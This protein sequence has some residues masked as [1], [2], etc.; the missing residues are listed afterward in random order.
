MLLADH[1]AEVVRVDR[2]GAGPPPAHVAREFDVV[3]RGRRSIV[4]DLKHPA[5]VETFL[6]LVE[7]A[8]G[9]LEGFRP[10]VMERLGLGPEICLARNPRLV[11]G[12]MTGFGQEGPLSQAAG[13]DLNYL[14]LTGALHAI[15]RPGERP[16][17]PLNLVAD[18]G[19]GTM[20]L[21]FGM[22]CALLE[23]ER[24]GRGQVVD[25]AM[26]DGVA[27]LAASYYGM[28]AA[29]KWGEARGTNLLDGGCPFYETY[30]TKDGRHVAV[31]ALENK[32]FAELVGRLGL[33]DGWVARQMDRSLWPELRR[34][35]AAI[36][37]TKS[38]DE[39]VA[40]LE[41][42][43]ACVTGVLT[44]SEAPSHPHNATRELFFVNTGTPQPVPAPRFSR[45]VPETPRPAPPTGADTA[46][47]L[48][49]WGC[50]TAPAG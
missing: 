47:V 7:K 42:T 18:Y 30:E 9:L 19:G 39:W 38:R 10:G 37:M 14:S 36:F 28:T 1:G 22:V 48:A 29:G 8:D 35:L 11:F 32:F 46:A 5:G 24:S 43:D 44:F 13:H 4:L 6:T 12:R 49:E 20:F 21:A 40:A 26:T 41:G 50:R 34:T 31:A 16:V 3:G 45:S 17:P 27:I 25:A 2:P 33:D 23:R 15:G